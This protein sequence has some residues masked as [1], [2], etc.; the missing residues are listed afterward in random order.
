MR[1]G[2]L[3]RLR[4]DDRFYARGEGEFMSMPGIVRRGELVLVLEPPGEVSG[5]ALVL[6]PTLGKGVIYYHSLEVMVD[7]R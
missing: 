4:C 1:R 6:H 7:A 2:D 3:V 5:N